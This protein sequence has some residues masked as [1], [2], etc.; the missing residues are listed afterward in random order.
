M[1]LYEYICIHILIY[2]FDSPPH[3][4]G[5]VLI[6]YTYGLYISEYAITKFPFASLNFTGI[7]KAITCKITL[8]HFFGQFQTK[9]SV[10]LVWQ[11]AGIFAMSRKM[12]L[13]LW[14]W[15]GCCTH[16]HVIWPGVSQLLRIDNVFLSQH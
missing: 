6:L 9:A 8:F 3:N 10:M 14:L 2:N 15:G 12:R 11:L 16:V 5:L 1:H 4:Q 13:V 7:I